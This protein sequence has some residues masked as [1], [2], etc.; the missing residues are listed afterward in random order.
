MQELIDKSPTPNEFY[1]NVL[2]VYPDAIQT[3]YEPFHTI[4]AGKYNITY[5]LAEEW[6]FGVHVRYGGI[7]LGTYYHN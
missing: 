7:S 5:H 4:Q 6:D 3:K 2:S 1:K